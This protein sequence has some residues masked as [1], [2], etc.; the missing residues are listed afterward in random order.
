MVAR[1]QV[2]V[3]YLADSAL[4][5]A[6]IAWSKYDGTGREVN[7]AG[8]S[9]APP[10]ESGLDALQHGW[11]LIQAS[12]LIDHVPGSEFRT[13]YLRYEFFF[14]KILE[15]DDGRTTTA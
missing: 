4:D 13:G 14:E 5:S 8:D 12:P 10:Y 7:M 9:E 15:V 2:L 1:Q 6:V 11:R 3:L